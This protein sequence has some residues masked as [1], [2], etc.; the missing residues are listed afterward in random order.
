MKDQKEQK[1][2]EQ[3]TPKLLTSFYEGRSR[4]VKNTM[5]KFTVERETENIIAR[6]ESDGKLIIQLK[7]ASAVNKNN[8]SKIR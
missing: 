2:P 7:S 6:K 4:D 5:S 3:G 8:Y 1:K